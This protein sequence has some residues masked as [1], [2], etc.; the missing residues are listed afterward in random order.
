MANRPGNITNPTGKGG[1]QERPEDQKKGGAWSSE[2]SQAYCLRRFLNMKEEEFINWGKENDIKTRTVAQVIAYER[3][4]ESRLEL[5]SY[6]EVSNRTEGMPNQ[7]TDITSDG[8][9]IEGVIIYKPE[10]NV[11]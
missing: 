4:K 11:E 8:E 5:N 3:V 7:S 10:K 6:R 2:N 9:K 1:F